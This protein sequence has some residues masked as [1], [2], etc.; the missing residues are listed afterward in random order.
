MLDPSPRVTGIRLIKNIFAARLEI[1]RAVE[2][3]KMR[4]KVFR[5]TKASREIRVKTVTLELPF[6][7]RQTNLYAIHL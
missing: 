2:A 6:G 4:A 5:A 1:S 7:L 3:R